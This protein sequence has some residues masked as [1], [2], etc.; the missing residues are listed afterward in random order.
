MK[1]YKKIIKE[2]N[3]VYKTICDI[4]GKKIKNYGYQHSD[5]TIEGEYGD[6]YP[7]FI[8]ISRYSIDCCWKCFKN[9]IIPILKK[10]LKVEFN[11]V[12]IDD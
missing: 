11:K 3:V 4:C 1:K 2:D 5:V 12:K 7:E 6:Y 9:K 10:E 8:S